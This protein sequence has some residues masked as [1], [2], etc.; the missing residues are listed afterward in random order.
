MDFAEANII[1]EWE[2]NAFGEIGTPI[3]HRDLKTSTDWSKSSAALTFTRIQLIPLVD[4][5][6]RVW[7]ITFNYEGTFDPVGNGHWEFTGEFEINAFGGL[8]FNK[9]E[10]VSRSLLDFAIDGKP[11]DYVRKGDDVVV[12]TPPI[13]VEQVE[14]LKASVP[15]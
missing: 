3:I 14:Y 5:E 1:I 15:Q 2:G 4:V 6:P 11:E 7:P 12:A 8:K 9:H 13:P 10:V